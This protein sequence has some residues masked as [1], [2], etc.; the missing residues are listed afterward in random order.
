MASTVRTV[1]ASALVCNKLIS[2]ALQ[3]HEVL[4]EEDIVFGANY[5]CSLNLDTEKLALLLLMM[6][7]DTNTGRF[8]LS[9]N[10]ELDNAL[11]IRD[12]SI[13]RR[14]LSGENYLIEL[15]DNPEL[16]DVEKATVERMLT[17]EY[18][19]ISATLKQAEPLLARGQLGAEDLLLPCTEVERVSVQL[20]EQQATLYSR[21]Y[22]QVCL[23][24]TFAGGS[25]IPS[26][27]YTVDQVAGAASPNT[28]CFETMELIAALTQDP[29]INP[30]TQQPFSDLAL[31]LLLPRFA[32]EIKLYRRYLKQLRS[33]G[34]SA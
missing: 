18:Q 23:K 29:P 17:R 2:Q 32:K 10:H 8:A 27:I 15:Y 9:F 31:S 34:L 5:V 3:S 4:T 33:A 16:T 19:A 7:R 30:T 12:A 25:Q 28:Y 1:P 26:V 24:E 22:D 13:L 20:G 21:C 6:S 14:I 11:K